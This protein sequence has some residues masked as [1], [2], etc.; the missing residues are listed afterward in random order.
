MSDQTFKLVGAR[1]FEPPASCTPFKRGRDGETS[2][3]PTDGSD[4]QNRENSPTVVSGLSRGLNLNPERSDDRA[5]SESVQSIESLMAS[6]PQ[7][8]LVAML[9][10]ALKK[11][12]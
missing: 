1:G 5:N 12:D 4:I 10:E 9:L 3:N 6:L 7:D 11:R 8:Q 2:I